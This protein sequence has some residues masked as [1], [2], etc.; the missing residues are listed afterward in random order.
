MSVEV[1]HRARKMLLIIAMVCAGMSIQAVLAGNASADKQPKAIGEYVHNVWQVADGLP[2]NAVQA[3]AKTP[4]GYLWLA[5]EEGLVRF[6]GVR[7]TVFDRKNTEEIKDEDIR[8]L[9]V[10]RDGS[11]WFGTLTGHLVQLKDG[12]FFARGGK[13]ELGGNSIGAIYEDELGSIWVATHGS[14]LYEYRDGKFRRYG[15]KDGLANNSVSSIAADGEGGLWI[16]TDGGLSRLSEG[17]FKSY[18]RNDGE[19]IGAIWSLYR[20]ASG[21]LWIG[22]HKGGLDRYANGKFVSYTKKDG[23]PSI[24]ISAIYEDEQGSLWIGTLDGG[25]SRLR[26]GK[27][28][29]YGARDGL[30][31]NGVAALFGDSEGSI[32]IGTSNGGLNRLREGKFS[33]YST[34][35]GLS[36]PAV[37]TVFED[38]AGII[39]LGTNGGGVGRL[40]NGRITMQKGLGELS[41]K[42]VGPIYESKDGSLWISTDGGLGRWKNGKM[43]VYTDKQGLPNAKES[44][45]FLPPVVVK[46]ITEDTEGK[47]WF[48]TDGGGL[49]RFEN[50]NFTTYTTADGLASDVVFGLTADRNGGLWIATNKG[51]CHFQNGAFATFTTKDGLA[52][53]VVLTVFQDKEGT[54]WI[55]TQDGM[56]RFKGGKFTSYYSRDGLLDELIFVIMEDELGNLW[57]SCNRGIFRVSKKD[58]NDFAEGRLKSFSSTAY[59]E[60][61]GMKNRECDGGIQAAGWKSHD[62]KLWFPTI[63]G[64][65]MVDPNHLPL[66]RQ[67]PPVHIEQFIAGRINVND[68]REVRLPAGRAS[69]E[70]HY[71]ALSY[72]AP[73]KIQFRY[74][75]DGFDKDWVDAGNRRTAYYTNVPPGKYVF[76][77]IASNNDGLWNQ[78]GDLLAIRI[79]PRYYETYWFAG[80]CLLAIGILVVGLY[81]ARVRVLKHHEQVLAARVDKRTHE[82]RQ[83]I[84]ERERVEWALRQAEEKYRSIFE[85]SIVG[86]FQTTPEGQIISANPALVRM[87]GYE[88]VGQMMADRSDISTQAYVDRGRRE[89]FKREME[90]NGMVENFEYE[91]YGKDGTRIWFAENARIVRDAGSGAVSYVGTSENITE[92]KQAQEKLEQEIAERKRAEEAAE[93]ANHAKSTFLANMSHEIRTPMNGIMGMTEL[94]LETDL[95][96]EQRENLNMVKVSAESLLGVINDILDFSKIEAGKL[97][98]ES[99]AFSLR[100]SLEETMKTLSFRAHQKGLELVDEVSVGVPDAVVGDPGRLRQVIVNLIGN[101]IKFTEKGEVVLRVENESQSEGEVWLHFSVSDTGVG[102]AAE[103]QGAI[104]GAFEQAD[105]STTRKFGGTGLGLAISWRLVEM[106]GGRVWVES[107]LGKG[108]TFHFTARLGLQREASPTGSLM[109][110]EKLRN[111]RVLIVDDNATNRRVLTGMLNHWDMKPT[112]VSGGNEALRMI[113]EAKATGGG[114]RLILVDAQMPDLDGFELAKLIRQDTELGGTTIMMLTSVGYLG[115]AARCRAAGIS[116]YLTKPIRQAELLMAVRLALGEKREAQDDKQLV[117]RHT[118]REGR[119]HLRILLAEDN[120]VNQKLAVKLLEKRGHRVKLAQ[121]GKEALAAMELEKFD[122]VLMDVQMPEMDGF[123]AT[124]AIRAQEMRSGGHIP[125]VAMTAH[126]LKGDEERCLAAGMDGYLSKPIRMQELDSLLEKTAQENLAVAPV[127][128]VKD[129]K[130]NDS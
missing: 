21:N 40:A 15:T 48:G 99:I 67:A 24:S 101:A 57:M 104:F 5:T 49:A 117:T 33:T 126:S 76:R 84:A 8:A 54:L 69:M 12:K 60:A 61:D 89:E 88:S 62:G 27:F 110:V 6:D 36:V 13:D 114:F 91:V 109:D 118:I 32:W 74:K 16:G 7:F 73:G 98:F 112:Q 14:G 19:S 45:G 51:L 59:G 90:I 78:T 28:E 127:L 128:A 94:V 68:P 26:D 72:L 17:R 35:E 123:E 38:H 77:V 108:S 41:G 115:D 44:S 80:L 106:M 43:T 121:N 119:T 30:S 71:T 111:L 95:T 63:D 53:D 120:V 4:D 20:D 130:R 34:A 50:G 79:P 107:E 82:L 58:L 42:M 113:R 10:S 92:R 25:V 97:N 65:V 55:G 86:I 31:D 37:W 56:N 47:I 93:A 11:L 75:M 29:N 23:L 52:N 81:R 66:N 83:E 124:A 1:Y 100:E 125:I 46:A 3:I 87:Y 18:T 2:E 22:T 102:I 129:G 64:V 103:K 116:A 39:W 122:I 85:E 9:C 96:Q 105:D 70:I